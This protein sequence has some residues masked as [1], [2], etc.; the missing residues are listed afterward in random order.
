[1]S[2]KPNV[3]NVRKTKRTSFFTRKSN[4][5]VNEVISRWR[6]SMEECLLPNDIVKVVVD[7]QHLPRSP[8][9]TLV[10]TGR[11]MEKAMWLE[12]SLPS[13]FIEAKVGLNFEDQKQRQQ[14]YL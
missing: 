14:T 5:C 3:S 11:T 10:H 2:A 1:M 8:R 13:G 12:L 4:H 9:A 7:G 6:F